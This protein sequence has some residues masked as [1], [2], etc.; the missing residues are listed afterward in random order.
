M[1][2]NM[3]RFGSAMF[4]EFSQIKF[5]HGLCNHNVA[6]LYGAIRLAGTAGLVLE[7]A[8]MQVNTTFNPPLG[9]IGA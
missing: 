3:A 5:V 4:L 8:T 2:H 6:T 1:R 7:H 9:N